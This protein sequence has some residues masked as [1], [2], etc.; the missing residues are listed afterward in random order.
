MT[1]RRNDIFFEEQKDNQR[2]VNKK[3]NIFLICLATASV[4]WLMV[5]L[6][7]TYN[8]NVVFSVTYKGIQKNKIL[9]PSSDTIIIAGIQSSGYNIIYDRILKNKY[10]LQI[11]LNQYRAAYNGKFYEI[12]IETATLSNRILSFFNPGEKLVSLYPGNLRVKLEK[13]YTK[14]VP[15]KVNVNMTFKKQYSIYKD[16]YL[17]PDSVFITGSKKII[18]YI[19]FVETESQELKDLSENTYLILKLINP[20]SNFS[21]RYSADEVKIYIPVAQYTEEFVDVPLVFD[22][23]PGNF[24]VIA[25]PDKVRCYFL[26]SIPDHKKIAVDDFKA[27]FREADLFH[28]KHNIDKVILKKVPS[29]ARVQRIEPD[30]VEYLIRKK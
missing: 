1:S 21:L 27:G 28:S 26:V 19:N 24:Q 30:N 11:D 18:D 23:V 9:V 2:R 6:A 7:D 17:N 15:V 22:S 13:A 14:K 5:K 4:L 20:M 16:I 10:N 3:L 29:Y 12:N 25:Y 8:H